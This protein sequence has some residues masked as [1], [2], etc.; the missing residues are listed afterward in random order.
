MRELIALSEEKGADR[1]V[2]VTS[3][4]EMI[5]LIFYCG[6]KVLGELSGSVTL[7]KELH[8]QK[9]KPLIEDVPFCVKSEEEDAEKIAH[10]FGA[11][12]YEGD[13]VYTFMVYRKG[14][15]D[16][17]RL[18]ISENGVGP[19]ICIASVKYEGNH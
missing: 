17:Y 14:L 11:H 13:R 4:G 1:L 3:K 6:W 12:L 5:S 10:L 18:D 16:F 7:R 19:R 15:I 8:I 2:I 9:M